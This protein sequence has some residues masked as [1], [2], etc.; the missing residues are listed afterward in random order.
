MVVLIPCQ[1]GGQIEAITV[2]LQFFAPVA[3][4]VE[5]Q[6][7]NHRVGKVQGVTASGGVVV[8]ALVILA[9]IVGVIEPAI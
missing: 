1:G 4:G 9:V 3:Q 8:I 5:G 7:L 2:N 6:F